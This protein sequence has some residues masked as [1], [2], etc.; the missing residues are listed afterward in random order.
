MKIN[1]K[2]KV[3]AALIK[4][5]GKIQYLFGELDE[6]ATEEVQKDIEKLMD[7]LSGRG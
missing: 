2:Q 1:E 4:L 3:M 5:D 7:L 6:D